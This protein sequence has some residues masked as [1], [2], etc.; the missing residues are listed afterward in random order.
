[1]EGFV[2]DTGTGELTHLVDA[3]GTIWREYG[4]ITQPAFALIG[5]DGEIEV[6]NGALGADGLRDA[7]ER[8]AEG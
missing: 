3:E 1:M 5:A 8:L 4:V 6:I 2:A 7:V